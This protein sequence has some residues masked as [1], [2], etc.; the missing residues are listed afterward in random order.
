M[1]FI[2]EEGFLGMRDSFLRGILKEEIL[3]VPKF[4][5]PECTLGTRGFRERGQREIYHLKSLETVL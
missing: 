1:R 3:G 5:K 4:E 2:L